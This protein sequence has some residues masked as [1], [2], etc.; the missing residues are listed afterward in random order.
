M[1][2]KEVQIDS[3]NGEEVSRIDNLVKNLEINERI[4]SNIEQLT[5]EV[6]TVVSDSSK[7]IVSNLSLKIISES[8][9]LENQKKIASDIYKSVKPVI[10]GFISDPN[11]NNTI[12]I[13]KVLSQ[14]IKQLEINTDKSTS[15]TD[16]K[17]IAIQLG[18]I[19]IK[20]AM[21]EDNGEEEVL[22]LYDIIAEP[23][24]E[25][26]IDVSKVV[27]VVIQDVAAKCCPSILDLFKRA[28]ASK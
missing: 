24:L 15:G 25:A 23:T 19:L 1:T 12:K 20:E 14:V 8:T 28:K 10:E 17:A 11:I 13:T 27:N 4:E 16:K 21:T 18:R 6:S 26:M 7:V 22:M 5:L 2:D 9:L 3:I